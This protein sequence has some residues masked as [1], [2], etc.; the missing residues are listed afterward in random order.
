MQIRL[1]LTSGVLLAA[2]GVAGLAGGGILWNFQGRELGLGSTITALV[3]LG[4]SF[5]LLRPTPKE[6]I[7][8]VG[9]NNSTLNLQAP[10]ASITGLFLAAVGTFGLA[11]SGILWNFKGLEFGLTGTITAVVALLL[12]FLFLW[13]LSKSVSE[14][15]EP[16]INTTQVKIE[17]LQ[18]SAPTTAEE[19]ARELADAQKEA[20]PVALT[21]FAPD[22]LLPGQTLPSRRRKAGSSMERYREIANELFKN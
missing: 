3:L 5:V 7:I 21:T 15:V 22:Y 16:K 10:K 17:T 8:V 14:V 13:P 19:I 6:A 11:T 12:S 1:G 4:I 20:K 18:T 9:D 2:L